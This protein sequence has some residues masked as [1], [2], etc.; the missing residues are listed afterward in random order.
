MGEVLGAFGLLD[1]LYLLLGRVL[2]Y[3]P[4]TYKIEGTHKF[5]SK[6]TVHSWEGYK[7][8]EL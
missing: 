5:V 6:I 8:R 7:M 1:L 3:G 4:G 2:I